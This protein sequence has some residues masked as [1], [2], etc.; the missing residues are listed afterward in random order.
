[1]SQKRSR[2]GRKQSQQRPRHAPQI[3]RAMGP[4][5]LLR[6]V[7]DLLPADPEDSLVLVLFTRSSGRRSRTHG[8]M[9][10]DLRHTDDP[11]ELQAWAEAV[12]GQVLQVDGVTGVAVAA[13]TP[14]RFA[15]SGRPPAAAQVR[16]MAEQAATMGL[17]VLDRFVVAEDGWGSLD[18]PLLPRG[19]N[20]LALLE[21]EAGRERP[22]D[23]LAA[24][25][26]APDEQVDRFAEQYLAW[27]SQPEGPG[28]VLHGVV[29]S[30]PGTA[31]SGVFG[32][33][34]TT[35]RLEPPRAESAM[36]RYRWGR[37]VDAV[38]DL[39]EGILEPHDEHDRPCPCRPLLLALVVR[40]GL[41]GLLLA[42]IGWGPAFGREIWTAMSAPSGR[43]RS[44]DRMV[45]AISG[46][47][48]RRPDIDRIGAAI[49]A[50][51]EVAGYVDTARTGAGVDEALSWLHWASGASSAAG[52][53]AARSLEQH[54][55][56][57]IA[58]ILLEKTRRGVL[59]QW[60]YRQ[61]PT[62]A[63][64]FGALL[65]ERS[66]VGTDASADRS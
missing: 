17:E 37:D 12:L 16:V 48:F 10:V 29:L 41:I 33:A 20:P 44:I 8:A 4:E 62:K 66:R 35:P 32:P 52:A 7:P 2:A 21:R 47:R 40:Q 58:P 53:L 60:A 64:R 50:L 63:D 57:D 15:P 46:G 22:R 23:P 1:M 13:Y 25:E 26:P 27:W 36:D 14:E 54:D 24:V 6:H 34:S 61:D 38:V 39:I 42:Q 18:D 31:P 30:V 28:G 19:G 11:V 5:D 51:H 65:E 9:R 56:R 49:E 43:E 45:A 55:D 3:V 59:P